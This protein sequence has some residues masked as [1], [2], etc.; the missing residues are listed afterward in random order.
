MGVIESAGETE[1]SQVAG[2]LQKDQQTLVTDSKAMS[3]D[4]HFFE[5]GRG[6]DDAQDS[7]LEELLLPTLSF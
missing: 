6:F 7:F 1:V 2:E 4:V 3:R 5:K